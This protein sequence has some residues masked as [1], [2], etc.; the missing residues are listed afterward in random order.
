[1]EIPGI[2]HVA[3]AHR[4]PLTTEESFLAVAEGVVPKSELELPECTWLNVSS[5]YFAAMKIQ[6]RSGRLFR[7]GGETEKVA[8][9]SESAARRI[10]PGQDP[11]GRRVNKPGSEAKDDFSRVVGVVGDVRSSGLDR[12]PVAAI[13]RPYEQRGGR[14]TAFG[15]VVQTDAAPQA[16]I[17]AMRGVVRRVDP[18]V[19]VPE[20]RPM[21][22]LIARSVQPRLFQA[23]L[24]SAFALIAV[25]LAAVGIYGVVAYSISQR[26]KEIGVRIAL[27]ADRQDISRLVFQNG[28]TPVAVGLSIGLLAACL[29][30]RLMASLLFQVHALDPLSFTV[31]PLVLVLAAAAPCW[32]TARHAA[33]IDPVDALRLE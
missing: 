5:E 2:V 32:L 25:L 3:A 4:L 12:A 15:I 18:G 21:D 27:G 9:V 28:M 16:L 24:L 11:I 31:A 17:G 20:I 14:P 13:Y 19:P 33:R 8:L 1:M 10:W 29:F 26:R 7:D 23:A 30:A 6:L 22:A